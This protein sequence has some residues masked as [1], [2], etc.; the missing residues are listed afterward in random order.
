LERSGYQHV[1]DPHGLRS[2]YYYLPQP[3][4]LP[5]HLHHT[6]WVAD[7]SI[8]FLKR[9]DG[10]RPF[11]LWSSFIKPHPPFET[12]NP[13]G[14]L[15]RSAEMPDPIKA[16]DGAEHQGFWNLVQNRY[17]Y[18][19]G[20]S[21]DH[22]LRTQRAAYYASIS[23]IDYQI[24]RILEALGDERDNT[25][26]VFTSDHGE[27]LGDFGCF[28]K[29][30]MLEPAVRVPL[31][32]SQ[33]GVFA[34]GAAC[35]EPVTLLDLFPTFIETAG[36]LEPRPYERANS[37]R[38]LA[39][40][41][42]RREFVTSQF[43]QR[44]LGL[45]MITDADW[46]YIFSAADKKEWLFNLAKDPQELRNLNADPAATHA[47]ERLRDGMI[48]MLQKDGYE[49][50]V[51]G[52]HWRDYGL[53]RLPAG[54]RTGLLFQDPGKLA[55]DIDALGGYARPNKLRGRD[56]IAYTLP[57]AMDPVTGRVAFPVE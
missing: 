11:F 50:A 31:L 57:H 38:A 39:A 40:G 18:M 12:P 23:F 13:W 9:R 7:R 25:L 56:W 21:N 26:I 1:F 52:A 32:V 47:L 51:E 20:G 29:R 22:L 14:R 46:K 5:A 45:Y 4:Q 34:A 55:N 15:Y 36:S 43:S 30:C 54:N 28:G 17:K 37:L 10:Q 3:S 6:A 19:D 53:V 49:W 42:L 16:G 24:G 48:T 8:D 44:S 27:M 33:P 41:E 2:E 35:A